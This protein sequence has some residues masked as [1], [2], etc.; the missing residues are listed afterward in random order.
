MVRTGP[1]ESYHSVNLDYAF[2][3]IYISLSIN[4]YI[5]MCIYMYVYIN[6]VCYL[7]HVL[8]CPL[9][10]KT[11]SCFTDRTALAGVFSRWLRKR[12]YD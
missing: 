11:C 6:L 2:I 12:Y 5:F 1:L 8:F 3:T 7:I 10:L 9:V 4:I